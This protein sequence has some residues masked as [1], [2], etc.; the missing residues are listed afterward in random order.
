MHSNFTTQVSRK[1][2][3]QAKHAKSLTSVRTRLWVYANSFVCHAELDSAS[4]YGHQSNKIPGQARNDIKEVCAFTYLAI[5]S[6]LNELFQQL[7]TLLNWWMR[8]EHIIPRC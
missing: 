8:G 6:A 3:K 2:A 1:E 4:F 7:D 5:E